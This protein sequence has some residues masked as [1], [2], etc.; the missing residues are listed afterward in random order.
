MYRTT[1]LAGLLLAVV[2]LTGCNYGKKLT[3]KKGELY[4]TDKVTEDEANKLGEFLVERKYFTDDKEVT[5]QLNRE[6]GVYQVR[7]VV[8]DDYKSM[9]DVY[10]TAY[11]V[12][13]ARISHEVFDGKTV[14]IHLCN[15]R[16]KTREVVKPS[17]KQLQLM[18]LLKNVKADKKG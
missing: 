2:T 15:D 3:F 16:L 1:I 7:M 17:D 8:V 4:Y 6:D 9:K 5:V 11:Q 18:K 14:E 10:P 13:A 12:L